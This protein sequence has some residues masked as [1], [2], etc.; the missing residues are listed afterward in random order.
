MSAPGGSHILALSGGI[1]GAKLALGLYNAL[2][3]HQLTVVANT[4]DDFVH[5]GLHVS[6]DIDTLL[7][8]LAGINNTETGWGRAEESWHFM[9]ALEGLGGDTWFQLGDKDLAT[10]VERTRRVNAGESL[11][12][13]TERLAIALSVHAN[14][15]PM[16]DQR[17][18]T[19]VES[20][21]GPV[22]FQ[23]YFVK[24][25]CRPVVT[26]FQFDGAEQAEPNA[27]LIS[28]LTDPELA[29][30]IICPSNPYISIDPMLSLRGVREA[31]AD[32]SAPV[33]AVSPIIG[34]DSVKG[35][36]AKMM[37]EL[38]V[39]TS[40]AS[41]AS[42]YAGIIDGFVIDEQDEVSSLPAGL[43]ALRT[44]IMMN[45]L[46][47]RIRLAREVLE[48]CDVIAGEAS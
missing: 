10:N 7:Y 19:I 34:A 4:A 30:V 1:G 38:G 47:D 6:P 28:C 40:A 36:T 33:V 26:G 17:V 5:L 21:D 46:D 44:S 25:Q 32:C 37:R 23:E 2:D 41:V 27:A 20:L 8:T 31:L 12:A 48:F 11:T 9:A 13:I 3:P 45:T 42:H 22:P 39:E 15:I 35:P 24:Q 16:S 43:A 14:I 18:S 29:A